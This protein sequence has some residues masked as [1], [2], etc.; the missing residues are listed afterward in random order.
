M[1]NPPAGWY[2]NPYDRS[3]ERYWD[4]QNW[5]DH[6]RPV[7]PPPPPPTWGAYGAP[8]PTGPKPDNYLVW[9][10]LATLFC[11]LPLGIVAIVHAAKVDSAWSAGDCAGAVDASNKAKQFA[12]WAA[13]GGAVVA[14]L[15]A[16][17][18]VMVA[19]SEPY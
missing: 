18:F 15:Y 16:L 6:L 8:R 9:S 1:T 12:T 2:P 14:V 4:G 10:I 11:C 17:L 19:G 13:I 5:T 3:T 7:A